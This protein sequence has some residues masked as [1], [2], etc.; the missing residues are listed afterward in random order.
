MDRENLHRRM[1]HIETHLEEL[2]IELPAPPS[3]KASYASTCMTGDLMF[4]SGHLPV[5]NDGTILTGVVGPES[6][7]LSI[8]DAYAA[9]RQV[10]L[11]LLATLKSELGDLDRVDQVVKLFGIVNSHSDFKGQHLV[12]DGCSDLMAEVFGKPKGIHAR[13]AIGTNTLPLNIIVEIEAIVRIK[14]VD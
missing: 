6:G 5:A 7:G 11:N 4:L 12:L 2:G 13:S 14:P 9:A 10:G 1:V 3:P 8:D